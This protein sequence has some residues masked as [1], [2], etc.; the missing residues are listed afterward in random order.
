MNV[1]CYMNVEDSMKIINGVDIDKEFEFVFIFK[2]VMSFWVI[3]KLG[4]KYCFIMKF[5]IIF[6]VID[7]YDIYI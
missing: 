6:V 5:Y 3:N 7:I 1:M 2:V 4:V